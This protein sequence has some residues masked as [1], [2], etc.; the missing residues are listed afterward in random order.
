M[1][2]QLLPFQIDTYK[3]A[4]NTSNDNHGNQLITDLSVPI[5]IGHGRIEP[6]E[7]LRLAIYI[8]EELNKA[9]RIDKMPPEN[10][11]LEMAKEISKIKKKR[12]F[13]TRIKKISELQA[14]DSFLLA[15]NIVV[16][17]DINYFA[18]LNDQWDYASG[19]SRTSGFSVNTG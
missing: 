5:S 11:V 16:S 14:V 7:D 15:N 19:P 1:M 18:V 6:I 2:Y 3:S 12:F 17:H 8:L 10:V 13:D 9:G 4:G